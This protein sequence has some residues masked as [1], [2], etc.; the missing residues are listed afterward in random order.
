MQQ[1]L[2]SPTTITIVIPNDLSSRAAQSGYRIAHDLNLYHKLDV[3]IITDSVAVQ[4]LQNTNLGA[5][6]LV[7]VGS[8]RDQFAGEILKEG[9]TPFHVQ[10][11]SL[12]FRG[13]SFIR[14]ASSA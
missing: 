7:V 9:K 8:P 12:S 4:R 14:K 3:D 5:G 1:I 11:G 13:E 2:K 6:N 10:D